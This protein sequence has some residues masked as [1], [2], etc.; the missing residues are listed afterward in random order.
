MFSIAFVPICSKIFITKIFL[1]ILHSFVSCNTLP[2]RYLP[3]F[4]CINAR[5]NE[6]HV[7]DYKMSYIM[8]II[9]TSISLINYQFCYICFGYP[10]CFTAW[11]WLKILAIK[12]MDGLVLHKARRSY[13]Q[14]NDWIH[15]YQIMEFYTD[16]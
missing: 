16:F 15:S 11:M 5:L 9:M 12:A 13:R 10:W 2:L 1:W 4:H 14:K 8:P 7:L 3:K 6:H